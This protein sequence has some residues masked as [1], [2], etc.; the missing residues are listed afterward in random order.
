MKSNFVNFSALI[1]YENIKDYS[2][3]HRVHKKGKKIGRYWV[4]TYNLVN[5]PLEPHFQ[6]ASPAS[7]LFSQPITYVLTR[8]Y[9]HGSTRLHVIASAHAQCS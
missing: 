8:S 9:D 2:V 3:L 6:P 5:G 7:F 1:A 4:R